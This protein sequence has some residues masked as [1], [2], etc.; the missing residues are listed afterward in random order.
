MKR[1]ASIACLAALAAA[2]AI[3]SP[4]WAQS[5]TAMQVYGPGTA[6][7]ATYLQDRSLRI[8]A[9]GWILG[10]WTGSNRT[11]EDHSVG[12]S[13]DSRGIVGEVARRCRDQPSASLFQT[14]KEVY[15]KLKAEH[16]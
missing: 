2:P 7:C 4:A 11:A 3:P 1:L 12:Q 14:S 16:R 10:F 13:T 8:N 6:S 9:D 15:D 5:G